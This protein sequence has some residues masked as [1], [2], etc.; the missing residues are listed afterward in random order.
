M[1]RKMAREPKGT[2]FETAPAGE[3]STPASPATRVSKIDQVIA[4][5]RHEGGATL[6]ELTS[7]TGWLPHSARAVLTGLRKKGH[8]IERSKRGEVSFYRI[9]SAA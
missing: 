6:E 7:A 1:P 4:L 8:V 5:L 2:A 9:T 3:T